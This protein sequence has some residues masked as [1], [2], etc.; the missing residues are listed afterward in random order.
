MEQKEMTDRTFTLQP[1]ILSALSGKTLDNPPIW[2]MRQAGRYLP[3][4]RALRAEAGSFMGLCF[5]PK[6]AVDVTLQP[7][8]RF[9]LDAAI[10]FSDILV[11]PYALGQALTFAEGEGPRLPPVRDM[12][13]IQALTFDATKLN[14]IY[15]TVAGVRAKLPADKALIGFA[16][17][18][19]T[20]ATYMVEG[21]GGHDFTHVK[22]MAYQ[23]PDV[24]A[25]LIDKIVDATIIYLNS[26]IEAGAQAIQIFESWAGVL[27]AQGFET[28][29][30]AP[31]RRIIA[32]V[33]AIHPHIPVIGFPR[34]G[35]VM[36]ETYAKQTGINAIGIDQLVS[37]AWAAA[38][39]QPH[40]CVQG[41][42]DPEILLAGG[43]ILQDRVISLCEALG[44]GPFIFNLGHGII[45]DTPISHV[46]KL[47]A[48][49]RAW[50]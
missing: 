43:D 36:L 10:L 1:L 14:P 41:N 25:A 42:L 16:G 4:Y 5:N 6:Y 11:I 19:W 39:L 24:F 26:Q 31:T 48:H 9:D 23:S 20:V 22:A 44:R 18:A 3:E 45:K 29:V 49:I 35:G 47:I 17:G 46:E 15:D 21:G 50:R 38:H 27:D 33:R 32:G 37:P 7:L 8:R 12:A 2:L 28:W 34:Q 13:S 40:V 30:M